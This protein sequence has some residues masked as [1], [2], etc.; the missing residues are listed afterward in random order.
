MARTVPPKRKAA[1]VRPPRSEWHA[2]TFKL[3]PELVAELDAI[4]A[5]E[6]RPRTRMIEIACREYVERRQRRDAAA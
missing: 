3:P 1:K 5:A 4:A 6:D 2:I